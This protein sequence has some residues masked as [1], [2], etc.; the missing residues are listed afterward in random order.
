MP[1]GVKFLKVLN[2]I[3]NLVLRE[4]IKKYGDKRETPKHIT[5]EELTAK[6]NE[7]QHFYDDYVEYKEFVF[8]NILPF[9]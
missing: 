9:S 6:R 3:V 4:E 2:E 1:G 8:L 5:F 7:M